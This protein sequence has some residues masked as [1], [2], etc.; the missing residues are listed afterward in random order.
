MNTKLKIGDVIE[1]PLPSKKKVYAHYLYKDR[2]GDLIGVFKD[3]CIA[4][5]EEPK[6]EAFY[7][8]EYLFR[9]LLTRVKDGMN[10]SHQ[11]IY[12]DEI[13]KA[14]GSVYPVLI[15]MAKDLSVNYDWKVVGNIKVKDFIYP[16]FIWRDGGP[17][18]RTEKAK[19][20]LYDGNKNIDLGYELPQQFKNLEYQTN[21]SPGALIQRIITGKT[22]D[23][24]LIKLG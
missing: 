3:Y 13:K 19:W 24:E 15:E 5:D 9:P 16:N 7:N 22:L 12:L 4:F 20:Y 18:K 23:E 10:I 14:L 1:I 17:E 6:M 2:W 11:L 8:R 21:Y